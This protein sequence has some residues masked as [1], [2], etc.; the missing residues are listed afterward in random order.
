MTVA[1]RKP[2]ATAPQ[3]RRARKEDAAAIARLFLISSDGL[4]AYIWSRLAAPGETLAAVGARRYARTGT[5]FSFENC[6]LATVDGAVAGMA[7]AFPMPARAAGE[8]EHDPVLAPYAALEDAG[9]LYLS[10]LAV[11]D[12]HRGQGIGGELMDHVEGLAI[13]TGC[14][15]VS[16]ICFERNEGAMQFYR[17]RGYREVARRPLV[18][19]P[20]LRYAAGD[21]VLLVRSA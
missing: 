6:L 17:R 11:N 2:P 20:T 12:E 9:S 18:P 10:G 15:R 14:G 19:H 8:V 7:H 13:E 4:A 21:A 5:A 1:L 3:V 16:L